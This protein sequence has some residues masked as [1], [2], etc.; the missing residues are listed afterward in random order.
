MDNSV[1]G[2]SQSNAG[3][4]A[5]SSACG[6][7]VNGRRV[8]LERLLCTVRVTAPKHVSSKA[9][10]VGGILT[11]ARVP[12]VLTVVCVWVAGK[13]SPLH[14]LILGTGWL[15]PRPRFPSLTTQLTVN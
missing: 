10:A 14:P 1:I 13:K 12:C 2:R 8:R 4:S 6:H 15:I 3:E 9:H 7:A 5:A 11:T